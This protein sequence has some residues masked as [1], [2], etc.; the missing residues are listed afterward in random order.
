MK[1]IVAVI[2]LLLVMAAGIGGYYYYRQSTTEKDVIEASGNIEATEVHVGAEI[3]GKLLELKKSEGDEVAKDEI[4]ALI[5]EELLK[6][7]VDQ[8]QAALA[9]AQLSPSP[10]QLALARQNLNVAELNLKKA[11]I[12]SPI[13]GLVVARP[14]ETGE[15]VT[16]GATL[17]TIA[18]LDSVTL[19]VYIPEDQLGNVKVGKAADVTVDGFPDRTFKGTIKRIAD[20]AEFTPSNVITKEQRVNMV[21]AVTIQLENKDHD[22]KPGMPADATISTK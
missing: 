18:N 17:Y 16:P 12:A 15:V 13:S 10:Q 4:V 22:L 7:Q 6:A 5:D 8:A 2:V 19:V 21:F 3:P 14:F 20:E 9:V 11:T 1:R